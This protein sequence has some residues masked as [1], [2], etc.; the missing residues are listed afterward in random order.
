V[1]NWIITAPI[2]G[3]ILADTY[4]VTKALNSAAVIE[5]LTCGFG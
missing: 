5:G 2:F 3:S 1:I 4:T